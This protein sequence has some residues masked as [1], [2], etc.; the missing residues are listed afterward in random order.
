MVCKNCGV[1]NPDGVA[2]CRVCGS[3]EWVEEVVTP[4]AE[5]ETKTCPKCGKELALKAKFCNGCGAKQEEEPAVVVEEVPAPVVEEPAPVVEESP[6]AEPETKTCPKCGK[7]LAVKAKF[8]NGCGAKQEE[9]AVAVVEEVP[10][11]V[12]EEP[13]PVVEE[14][15]VAEPETKTCPKCGKEL[16][17]KA[18]FCN[19]CGAKQEE[20]PAVVVEEV[21]APVVE[22]PAPVV[23][24]SPVAEP[25]TKTCPKCGKELAVKAK[26]CNGCGAKQEEEAVAVVEEVPAPVVEEPVPVVEEVAPIVAEPETKICPKCG[27]ELPKRVKF[28]TGCGA[29]QEDVA[30]TTKTCPGCGKILPLEAKF[31]LDCGMKQ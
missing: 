18:K 26:F 2:A 21:P 30:P 25:E 3:N 6:V 23:E 22:E 12:V 13:A 29:K 16:A 8:C 7:E 4:A 31:C 11:P 5:P 14:S 27:K 15:P 17:L 9:E 24:E 1:K 28:C 10:A 19:G 20:E